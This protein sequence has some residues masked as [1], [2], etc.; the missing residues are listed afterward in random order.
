MKT[1]AQKIMAVVDSQVFNR[2]LSYAIKSGK[3]KTAGEY[4]LALIEVLEALPDTEDVDLDAEYLSAAFV[5]NKTPQGFDFWS[6]IAMLD[7]ADE[8]FYE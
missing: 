2:T 1:S 5:F 3:V 6:E 4:T 7:I 8:V